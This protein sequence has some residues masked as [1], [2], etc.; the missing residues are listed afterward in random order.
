MYPFSFKKDYALK[1][2][3]CVP[4]MKGIIL[5]AKGKL[6]AHFTGSD[7]DFREVTDFDRSIK[8][9]HPSDARCLKCGVC[10]PKLDASKAAGRVAPV[11]YYEVS[12][13]A[14]QKLAVIPA[15]VTLAV[16]VDFSLPWDL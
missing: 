2:N 3:R 1:Q 10:K 16:A 6:P 15:A 14:W 4:V 5:Y 7:A 11:L 9:G 13:S 8:Y 12:G